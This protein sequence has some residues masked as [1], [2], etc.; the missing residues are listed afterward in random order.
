[1]KLMAMQWHLELVSSWLVHEW[2]LLGIFGLR[3]RRYRNRVFRYLAI[4]PSLQIDA[5]KI[6]VRLVEMFSPGAVMLS[7][8]S[9]FY[10]DHCIDCCCK[11]IFPQGTPEAGTGSVLLH[12]PTQN[13]VPH[14]SRHGISL[15]LGR[16]SEPDTTSVSLHSPMENPVAQSFQ[17][18]RSVLGRTAER[19][20]AWS[21]A[22]D[23]E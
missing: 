2:F 6:G 16:T 15:L 12:P 1:M 9:G 8:G 21:C 19:D 17:R 7:P 5:R 18:S 4:R 20:T 22:Y 14:S 13:P 3:Q 11:S 23:Q 10:I